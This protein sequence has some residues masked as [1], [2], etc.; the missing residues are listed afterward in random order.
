[1]SSHSSRSSHGATILQLSDFLFSTTASVGW[2]EVLASLHQSC[3]PSNQ[4][5]RILDGNC[6]GLSLGLLIFV[7]EFRGSWLKVWL[8]SPGRC[9][10]ER[11]SECREGLSVLLEA[12]IPFSALTLLYIICLWRSVHSILTVFQGDLILLCTLSACLVYFCLSW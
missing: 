6:G 7:N 9:C 12:K 2:S 3:K 10:V 11:C 5:S 8:V 4:A 1:M